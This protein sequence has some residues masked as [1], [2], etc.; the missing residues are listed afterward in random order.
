M[1]S[2]TSIV[3]GGV[4][5]LCGASGGVSLM[6]W[7][8]INGGGDRGMGLRC[9]MAGIKKRKQQNLTQR[10]QRQRKGYLR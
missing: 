2:R 1:I 10:V 9:G 7:M 3:W 6:A 4:A 5:G 8:S